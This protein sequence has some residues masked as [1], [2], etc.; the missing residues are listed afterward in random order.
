MHESKHTTR[1][2]KMSVSAHCPFKCTGSHH[3]LLESHVV[4][5][6]QCAASSSARMPVKLTLGSAFDIATWQPATTVCFEQHIL[7]YQH[8]LVCASIYRLAGA[9]QR[10]SSSCCRCSPR[11]RAGAPRRRT[12][13]PIA[14]VD[15][16]QYMSAWTKVLTYE[17]L[18]CVTSIFCICICTTLPNHSQTARSTILI[19]ATRPPSAA[20][21]AALNVVTATFGAMLVPMTFR[22][23]ARAPT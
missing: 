22:I 7:L 20:K 6:V 18:T 19:E 21:S 12:R 10:P 23:F 8:P 11:P 9:R 1:H 14:A 3:A 4:T 2:N 16:I 15:S 13:A 17:G 5:V